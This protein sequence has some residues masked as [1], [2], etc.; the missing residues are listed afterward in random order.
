MISAV[1]DKQGCVDGFQSLRVVDASI[2]PFLTLRL[3]RV[4]HLQVPKLEAII[5]VHVV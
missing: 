1:I 5:F 2:L 3:T 4:Y